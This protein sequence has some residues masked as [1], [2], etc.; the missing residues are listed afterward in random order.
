MN[1]RAAPDG[2]D[3]VDL[4]VHG[5]ELRLGLG[6]DVG[7]AGITVQRTDGSQLLDEGGAVEEVARLLLEHEA[8]R[9]PA[10]EGFDLLALVVALVDAKL[11]DLVARA[12][13]DGD[14]DVDAL[15]VGREH[16]ARRADLHAE[17]PLVVIQGAQHQHV[18]L[19]DVLLVGAS[20]AEREEAAVAGLHLVAQLGV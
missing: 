12:L 13:V 19:E 1:Q 6:L 7:V 11:A 18:A 10:A 16:H 17:V 3:D 8:K 4:L 14:R 15:P 2:H 20:R 9:A 5:I